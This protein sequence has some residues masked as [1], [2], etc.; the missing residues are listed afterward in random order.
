MKK[1]LLSLGLAAVMSGLLPI[2]AQGQPAASVSADTQAFEKEL[3]EAQA[4]MKLMQEQ[5]ERIHKTSDPQERQRL[6]QEHWNSM[7]SA[8]ASMNGMWGQGMMGCCGGGRHGH[9]M[10]MGGPNMRYYY[11]KLTPEQMKQRQYMSDQYMGMQQMMMNH[12]MQHQHW[13]SPQYNQGK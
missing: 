2:S 8:M 3:A 4:Q 7:Q 5:M 9:G 13:M 6:M 12:M 10:M 11:G 1:Y